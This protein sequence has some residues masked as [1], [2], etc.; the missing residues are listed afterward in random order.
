MVK[1]T[2]SKVGGSFLEIALSEATRGDIRQYI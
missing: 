1:A 2:V